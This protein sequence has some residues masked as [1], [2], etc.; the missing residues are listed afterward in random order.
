MPPLAGQWQSEDSNLGL[1]LKSVF[2]TRQKKKPQTITGGTYERE[3]LPQEEGWPSS[4]KAEGWAVPGQSP[5]PSS[6]PPKPQ[7]D[8]WEKA[9]QPT[10]FG[11]PSCG[12]AGLRLNDLAP[13]EGKLMPSLLHCIAHPNMPS[14]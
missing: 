14:L 7:Q 12:P 10:S 8:T 2:S 1:T 3:L 13:M 5:E 6:P 9:L 4:N 11:S